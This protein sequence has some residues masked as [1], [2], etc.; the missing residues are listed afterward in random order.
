MFKYIAIVFIAH[1]TFAVAQDE[2]MSIDCTIKD[3]K[4][5]VHFKA[6][7]LKSLKLNEAICLSLYNVDSDEFKEQQNIAFYDYGHTVKKTALDAFSP[8]NFDGVEKPFAG[9]IDTISQ[10]ELRAKKLPSFQ[11][12][13]GRRANTGKYLYYFNDVVQSAKF[14]LSADDSCK[15][16]QYAV[17]CHDLVKDFKVAVNPYKYS[18]AQKTARDTEHKLAVLAKRWDKFLTIGR[19]QT[20]LDIGLTTL[21]ENKHFKT[22]YLVGPPVRQW[23]LLHPNLVYEYVDAAPDGYQDK[24]S[25]AIEWLGVN[26]WSEESPFFGVP[27]GVS[28]ASV[29]SDRPGIDDAGHGLMFHFN[30]A[31]SIGWSRRNNEDG[32]YVSIDL[33]KAVS[34]KEQQFNRYKEK[35]SR[36]ND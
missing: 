7:Q 27:F 30:N 3:L 10:H 15:A 6:L 29:Y 34:D 17:S 24:L 16:S 19:S 8:F 5:S 28:L 14:D 26:W 36:F 1:S 13:L 2:A 23:S 12:A 31:Y 35:F 18:Y 21:L 11:T 33:L 20:F 4:P 22:G 32:F 25:V 9:F